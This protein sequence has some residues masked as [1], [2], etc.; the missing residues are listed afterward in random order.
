[1]L[2]AE[3]ESLEDEDREFEM[4]RRFVRLAHGAARR[5]AK[6][7]PNL[8]PRAAILKAV[9]AALREQQGR[10]AGAGTLP[11]PRPSPSGGAEG[12]DGTG[13]FEFEDATGDRTDDGGSRGGSGR[14]VRRGGKIVLLGV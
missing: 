4:A 8:H 2:E 10:T 3:L 14:W 7:P 9:K 13:E 5:V 11:P 6:V 12:S 1:M